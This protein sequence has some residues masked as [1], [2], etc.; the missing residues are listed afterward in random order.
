M[1]LCFDLLICDDW[2]Q[3]VPISC[4]HAP[5]DYAFGAWIIVWPAMLSHLQTFSFYVTSFNEQP[6]SNIPEITVLRVLNTMVH[7]F[8]IPVLVSSM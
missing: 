6:S 2:L 5:Y 8:A 1:H 3:T 7:V 4:F